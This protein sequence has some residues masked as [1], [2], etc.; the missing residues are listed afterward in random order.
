MG[1]LVLEKKTGEVGAENH[2]QTDC[3]SCKAGTDSCEQNK[4]E[5]L[6][7]LRSERKL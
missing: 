3:L 7:T 5:S 4:G 2:V 6:T 1:Y